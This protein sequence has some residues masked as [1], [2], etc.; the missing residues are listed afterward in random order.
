MNGLGEKLSHPWLTTRVAIALGIFFV[1]S[2][3]PKIVDPP[4]FARL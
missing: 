3:L 2:S 4:S 1:V